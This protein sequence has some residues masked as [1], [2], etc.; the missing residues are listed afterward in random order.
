MVDLEAVE[1]GARYWGSRAKISY[2]EAFET[3]RFVWDI[4]AGTVAKPAVADIAAEH[5][6]W[7]LAAEVEGLADQRLAGA[8]W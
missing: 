6:T 8:S 1:A 3:P 2:A 4:G 7:E 5:S